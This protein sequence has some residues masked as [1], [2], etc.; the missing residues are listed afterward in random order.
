M[1]D[2][3]RLLH[4]LRRA[5]LACRDT[6]GRRGRVVALDADD[7]LVAGDLHG[8]VENFRLILQR[9]NLAR[10]PRRHL[11]VQEL[12]HGP[13]RYP[14][15]GDKS[16]QLLDLFAALKCQYPNRVHFLPGNHELAQWTDRPI[17]KEEVDLNVQFHAGVG[18]AYGPRADDIY[19]AYLGLCAAAPLA[20]R[21]ANR[22]FLSHSL[23]SRTRLEAFDPALLEQDE[24]AAEDL[25]PGG[26]IY[27]L[28]WG[29]DTSP[30][31]V[32][33]FLRR[34]DADLLVTG[35]IPCDE[36]FAVPN[37]RQLVLDSVGA[38]ACTC[39][40]PAG[41]PLTHAELVAGV[42]VL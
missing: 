10:R 33:A 12:I 26:R 29:R 17:A 14:S 41:R 7:V 23:P 35:H 13:H 34:V 2:P 16:H 22:V 36:G 25:L 20:L 42:A 3:D 27:P 11:I 15:G 5:V 8:N 37:D 31:T 28:L 4:T 6:P 9:A 40:F 1:P 30:E 39:L 32:T 38:P 18:T 19:A 24:V 21:T